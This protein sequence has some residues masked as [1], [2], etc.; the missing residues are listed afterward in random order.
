LTDTRK[1]PLYATREVILPG[2]FFKVIRA[3]QD[4]ENS[5]FHNLNTECGFGHCF[6]HG[7]NA[8]EA[9][10]C[11]TFIASNFLQLFYYRRIKKSLGTQVELVRR[12]IKGL[13]QLKIKTEL[14]FNTT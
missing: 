12:M 14:M 6:V 1:D 11:L 5:I 2:L 8:I 9:V 3:I 7:G 10:L 4:I 13:Y